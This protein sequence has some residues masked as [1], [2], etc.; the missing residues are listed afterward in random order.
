MEQAIGQ[1]PQA[2][3]G[4]VGTE[5][6]PK[7]VVVSRAVRD[8]LQPHGFRPRDIGSGVGGGMA[9]NRRGGDDTHEMITCN[10]RL[11]GDPDR[12]E[13]TAGRYGNRGGFVEVTGLTLRGALD[14]VAVLPRPVRVDGSL[15]EG[16]YPSLDDALDDIA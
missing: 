4:P 15:A 8:L 9:W 6:D 11:S 5:I 10:G 13:W 3:G 2:A 16:I 7:A 1:E 14:A 12:A